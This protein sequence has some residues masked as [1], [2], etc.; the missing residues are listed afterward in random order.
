M[1]STRK[2]RILLGQ[3]G[4]RG[5]CLYAT[6]VARQIKTDFLGCHLTWAINSM[7]RSVIENNPFVDE[8]W[9]IPQNNIEDE[10]E[11]WTNFTREVERR[12]ESGEYDEV[13]LTQVYPGNC[14]N[15]DGTSRSSLFRG[16]PRPITV[17]LE[18]IVR[19]SDTEINNVTEFINKNK[20][21]LENYV[22]LFECAS[23]SGQSF[24]THEYAIKT[25]NLVV[26]KYKNV[27]FVLSSNIAIEKANKNIIDGSTLSF[28]ENAELTKYC[29]L[30]IGCS[31]GISWLATSDWAKPLPKIQLLDKNT[32]MFASMV[33]DAKYFGLRIDQ[34][35]EMTDCPANHL[36]DCIISI[37]KKGFTQARLKYHNEIPVIFDHYFNLLYGNLIKKREFL[38]VINSLSAA[39]ERY[40][41]NRD[42]IK[43]L[44]YILDN[45]F[46]PYLNMFWNSIDNSD[47]EKINVKN[48][49]IK[50]NKSSVILNSIGLVRLYVEY[51]HGNFKS[52]AKILFNDTVETY[53]PVSV[54]M[55]FLAWKRR[56]KSIRLTS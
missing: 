37:L 49:F 52:I 24:V 50:K 8:I 19:L 43:S 39:Y 15:Y 16:Y 10:L 11:V 38:K 53:F 48:I 23:T 22:I 40:Q 14:Q 3:L 44:R 31:S 46:F 33:H 9:E 1:E 4:K 20:I 18:P 2:K 54:R 30:L 17:P 34:I 45:I 35:I 56:W 28:K 25:A 5:D 6:T 29:S 12:K 36:A 7:C 55:F 13:F 42:G 21:I 41:Y 26:N 51:K 27:R 47:K 32:Y